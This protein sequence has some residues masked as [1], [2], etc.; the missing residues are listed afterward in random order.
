MVLPRIKRTIAADGIELTVNSEIRQ[1]ATNCKIIL[2]RH[3]VCS[4]PRIC[5]DLVIKAISKL[6]QVMHIT[7]IDFESRALQWERFVCIARCAKFNASCKCSASV[8]LFIRAS[9]FCDWCTVYCGHAIWVVKNIRPVLRTSLVRW[10]K[11]TYSCHTDCIPPTLRMLGLQSGKRI[12][13]TWM[14]PRDSRYAASPW[15][16]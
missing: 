11:A 5:L 4:E 10:Q 3:S 7:A 1:I 14:T 16:T 13:C 8:C 2:L 15:V 6:M 12:H 9:G